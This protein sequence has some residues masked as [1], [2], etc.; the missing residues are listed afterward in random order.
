MKKLPHGKSLI[1]SVIAEIT[2]D[3]EAKGT[4]FAYT[5]FTV[6]IPSA[7]VSV[8]LLSKRFY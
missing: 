7:G 1:V 5:P 2:E 6:F 8:W 4:L 3:N